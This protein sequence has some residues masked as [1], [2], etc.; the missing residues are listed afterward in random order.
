M[1]RTVALLAAAFLSAITLGSVGVAAQPVA[2]DFSLQP[3]NDGRA[4]LTLE[5]RGSGAHPST[6]STSIGYNQLIGLSPAIWQHGARALRFALVR[7]AGRLDCSGHA[8]GSQA[9]GTCTHTQDPEFV[10]FLQA[11]GVGSPT[12]RQAYA[13][14]VS[15]VTR[16][17][18]DAL[19]VNGYRTPSIEDV[20]SLGI[21]DVSPAYVHQL[22]TAG[23]RL[24]TA[25]DLVGFRIHK[26]TPALISS[27]RA[28]GYNRLT[29]DDLMAMAVHGVAPDF[30]NGFARLGYRNIA[31]DKLVELKIFGVTPEFVRSLE[32]DGVR[33]PSAEQLI[34]LRMAGYEPG[35][36]R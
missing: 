35:R 22:A 12:F 32:R 8:A 25:E 15:G 23:Y 18:V 24:G 7:D 26:V 9:L 28:L 21:F 30:I 27:Y 33:P 11:R 3:R 31:A 20:I 19:K 29:A 5:S 6:W 2:V 13:L 16:A 1:N 17:Q 14:T 10:T 34:R 4:Q 36:G